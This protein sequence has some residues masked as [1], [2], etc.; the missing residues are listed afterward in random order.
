MDGRRDNLQ[1]SRGRWTLARYL[2]TRSPEPMPPTVRAGDDMLH[3]AKMAVATA[4]GNAV[5]VV[6]DDGR[7]LGAV[8]NDRLARKVFEQLDPGLFV[9]EHARATTVL[10]SL[11]QSGPDFRPALAET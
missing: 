5:Y 11:G 1:L 2:A 10:L 4:G 9:D 8:S 3:V 7:Y 6:D